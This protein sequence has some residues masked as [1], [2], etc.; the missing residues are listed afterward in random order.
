MGVFIQA[1]DRIPADVRILHCTDSMEVDNS[2][3]TGESMPE[4]RVA[5]TEKEGSG[6][7]EA[8]NLAFFGTTVLKGNATCVVHAIGDTTF[9][10]KIARGI[11]SSRVKSTH[12]I[13]IEHF[14]HIIAVIAIIVGLASLAA[15]NAAPT[16]RDPPEILQNAAAALF[17]QVPEGLLPTVTI[18]LM[19]ASSQMVVRHVLVRKIDAVETLGCVSVFCSD[20]TGTLTKG[21]MTV[22]DFVIPKTTVNNIGSDGLQVFHRAGGVFEHAEC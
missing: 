12:E 15:N 14:V 17:A 9:L 8:R 18:S 2:A 11:S 13:Q 1:G 10:G 16:K 3:L 5:V 6:P 4:P 7:M 22:Q 20:K 21:E 19:I